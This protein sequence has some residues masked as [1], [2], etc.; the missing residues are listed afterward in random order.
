MDAALGDARARR[1]LP[2][3]AGL[4]AALA[5]A[6]AGR[7]SAAEPLRGQWHMDAPGNAAQP[8]ASGNGNPANPVGASFTF[9]NDGRFGGGYRFPSETS[10]FSAGSSPQ[11]Q[12]ATVTVA[13]WVRRSGVP[14][15]VKGIVSH[16]SAGGC[17][18]SSYAL[19]T[20]GSAFP[21]LKTRF[22]IFNGTTTVS[23]PPVPDSMWNGAWHLLA[24]TYDGAAVRLYLD[25]AEVGPGT[26]ATGS[27]GYGLARHNNL[28]IG[29]LDD[30]ACFEQTNFDGDIDEPQIYGRA[31]TA[32]EIA[33]LADPLATSPPDLFPAT[34]PPPKDPDGPTPQR[35]PH[36]EFAAKALAAKAGGGT[37]L[38]AGGTTGASRLLWDLNS[39]GRN[40]LVTAAGTRAVLVQA[41]GAS[42]SG[43]RLTAVGPG[44]TATTTQKFTAAPPLLRPALAK[45]LRL[46]ATITTSAPSGSALTLQQS[47]TPLRNQVCLK[48]ETVTFGFV[49]AAGCLLRTDRIEEVPDAERA[50]VQSHYQSPVFTRVVLAICSAAAR[51]EGS[52]KD[53]DDARAFFRQHYGGDPLDVDR[54]A[55]S[56]YV[57]KQPVKLNGLTI[58]PRGGG[59][60]VLYPGQERLI[61]SNAVLK[62]GKFTISE[63]V[64]DLN[65]SGNVKRT[66]SGVPEGTTALLTFDPA[67]SVP[68]IS[69]FPLAGTASLGLQ[70]RGGVRSSFAAV[71][72]QLPPAFNLFGGA[73]P[74]GDVQL[75]ASNADGGP[76]LD[77]LD[78]KVPQANLGAAYLS[79]VRFRYSRTG[80]IDNDL[81]EGT[82]CDAKEWK[83]QAALYIGGPPGPGST[84]IVLVP[85]PSQNG[86]GFCGGA[87]KHAGGKFVFGGAIPRPQVFPGVFLD[88]VDVAL[89]L[90]PTVFRGGGALSVG[91]ISKVTGEMLVAFASAGQPYRLSRG[92][93][94]G[95]FEQFAGR[96][97]TSTTIVVGGTVK[98][99]VPVFGELALGNGALL[100]SY[101]G[102]LAFGGSVRV[103]VPGMSITGGLNGWMEIGRRKFQLSGDAQACIGGLPFG[104][105]GFSV[106]L[107]SRGMTACINVGGKRRPNGTYKGGANPG[108]G[109][110]WGDLLPHI[111]LLDGCKPSLY[112]EKPSGA[113]AAADRLTFRVAPGER[114][115]ELQIRGVGAA[116]RVRITA[117]GGE[118]LTLATG[119]WAETKTMMALRQEGPT[120]TTYA[121]VKNGRPGTYTV[122]RL[123]GSAALKNLAETRPG[124]DTNFRARVTGSGPQRTLTYDLGRPARQRVTFFER[125]AEGAHAI[126]TA[127]SGRGTIRFAPAPGAPGVR[128][129]VSVATLAGAPIPDQVLATYRVSDEKVRAPAG[130]RVRRRGTSLQVSWRA[131]PGAR[132]YGV[133]VRSAGGPTRALRLGANARRATLRGVAEVFGGRVVV[134]AR[135]ARGRWSRP[136]TARYARTRAPF[137]VLQTA[138]RNEKRDARRRR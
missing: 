127:T 105:A 40:D 19:Y 109:Y 37:L 138:T 133:A 95:E 2:I 67:R 64:I 80:H 3:V 92:D 25:G 9:A 35:A 16:G 66:G 125:T 136:A 103:V 61:S 8:D 70:V 123:P 98:V 33:R 113:R 51:G 42:L 85:P 110:Y 100:Y 12:P 30:P 26:P 58:T 50:V 13:A 53:C 7:A 5:L 6:P 29:G 104:C 75:S 41:L 49:E 73:P 15:A 116:P 128:R 55:V 34:P 121:A 135:D 120:T 88:S 129:I 27:I 101:P 78:L 108:A 28:L 117:P 77:G 46:P 32:A 39:D 44:G 56:V 97:F 76:T 99:D 112:W 54:S 122:E 137:T 89:Q 83:A 68:G 72:V 1:V 10:Y 90:D 82:R 36:I 65:L 124:Y 114:A 106:N 62:W 91:D 45:T 132:A 126:G 115:K 52:Q 96:L 131:V 84:G 79:D 20:G 38:D 102:S 86:V 14:A 119:T 11:L 118:V 31:L 59:S 87:F 134:T 94:G 69:G 4:V 18:Y 22:Y 74:S 93:A 24:G 43:L 111:W 17:S 71:H 81:N 21:N 57:S 107:G 48:D 130:L 47:K 23:S 60:V 63:G